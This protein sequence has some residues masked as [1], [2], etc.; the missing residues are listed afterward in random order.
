VLPEF[1]ARAV[2]TEV[3]E[4]LERRRPEIA[5][6]PDKVRAETDAILEQKRK[7]YAGYELPAAYMDALVKEVTATVPERWRVGALAYTR[8]ESRGFELWRGGDVI[9]R[10]TYLFAGLTLG[11]IIVALPFIPIWEKWFP[12]AL[13]VAAFWLPDAQTFWLRRRYARQLG[14]IVANV[15]RAQPALDE[16]I[17]VADL[18]PPEGGTS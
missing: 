7:V 16:H 14:Q 10:L 5:A 4:H 13:A 1:T 8:L 18:L 11:G 12:F 6:D 2:S 15:E 17:T 9:A 3:I